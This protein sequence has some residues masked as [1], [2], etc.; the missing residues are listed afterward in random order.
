MT[1]KLDNYTTEG[2][3]ETAEL[4]YEST[5]D[6]YF[7]MTEYDIIHQIILKYSDCYDD[8][9]R[10]I[11][12]WKIIKEKRIKLL[13]SKDEITEIT[14][15]LTLCMYFGYLPGVKYALENGANPHIYDVYTE[16]EKVN[17]YLL[18]FLNFN[19]YKKFTEYERISVKT[20]IQIFTEI[21]KSIN[22]NPNIKI[23]IVTYTK[24]ITFLEYLCLTL[25][26]KIIK[27]LLDIRPDTVINFNYTSTIHKKYLCTIPDEDRL[28]KFG[29]RIDYSD[30][31]EVR[32]YNKICD[33]ILSKIENHLAK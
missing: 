21:F 26:Y 6:E 22:F 10:I 12:G 15:I 25:N 30:L 28:I 9:I 33:K 23:K 1:T 5:Y 24:Y 4:K 18:N 16:P 2:L 31:N 29:H 27:L 11:P 19:I 14:A 17:Q 13:Y 3:K 32:F 20:K 8:S 7:N